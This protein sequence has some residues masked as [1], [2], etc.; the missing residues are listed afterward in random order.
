MQASVH[1][2][3]DKVFV[4]LVAKLKQFFFFKKKKKEQHRRPKKC[5]LSNQPKAKIFLTNNTSRTAFSARGQEQILQTSL[6]ECVQK[7]S[8]KGVTGQCFSPQTSLLSCWLLG[9]SETRVLQPFPD[10][11]PV[12]L[13]SSSLNIFLP[14]A[15]PGSC[16]NLITH[17]VK[18][19]FL[20]LNL[21]L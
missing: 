15:F 3:A 2:S 7:Q 14:L 18:K 17:C 11:S 12:N 21:N 6:K 9:T 1:F 10:L 16:G 19:H 20:L 8:V 13:F 5:S 4:R